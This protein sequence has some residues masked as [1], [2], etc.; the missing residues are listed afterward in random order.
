MT[1]TA[2]ARLDDRRTATPARREVSLYPDR[3]EAV[4]DGRIEQRIGLDDIDTVRISVEPAGR[5]IQILCRVHGAGR[6]IA[7]GS[8]TRESAARWTPNALEFRRFVIALHE[9]V[10]GRGEIRFV[11][12][13][14]LSARLP[15]CA[16]AV[17]VAL[18]GL[19]FTGWMWAV[20]E[21][22]IMGIAGLFIAGGGFYAGWVFRPVKPVP[23]DPA[24]M[25]ANLHAQIARTGSSPDSA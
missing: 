1:E 5:D 9:T 8:L 14:P 7:M 24:D 10:R 18:A 20:R 22:A 19:V 3:I 11:E 21:N 13:A 23:Y 17:L 25:I 15:M 6:T 4:A 12:G 2:I 16:L